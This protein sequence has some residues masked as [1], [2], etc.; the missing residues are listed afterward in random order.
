MKKDNRREIY[1]YTMTVY[2]TLLMIMNGLGKSGRVERRTDR[3]AKA[4]YV[5]AVLC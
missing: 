3:V 1:M 5:T 2:I 4:D